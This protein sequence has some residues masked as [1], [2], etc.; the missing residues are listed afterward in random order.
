[1]GTHP[2]FE[3]DFDC[4]TVLRMVELVL[5]STGAELIKNGICSVESFFSDQ[6]ENI[7]WEPFSD[8]HLAK[9]IKVAHDTEDDVSV[10][11]EMEKLG[12]TNVCTA[13]S[14]VALSG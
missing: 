9:I 10:R 11:D 4:L 8:D 12:Y 1:M 3:S 5:E 7:G 2:I 13:Q 14:F 6:R